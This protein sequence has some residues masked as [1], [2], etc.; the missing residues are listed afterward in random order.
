MSSATRAPIGHGRG[1]AL[2]VCISA[3]SR[4]PKGATVVFISDNTRGG[5]TMETRFAALFVVLFVAHHVGDY[6]VQVDWQAIGK[7]LPTW[8][9][10][11]A[12]AS[13]VATYTGTL[14]LALLGASWRLGMPLGVG[15]TALGLAVSAVT[16]YAADRRV[17]F[18]RLALA[19]GH[20]AGWVDSGGL[21][22]LDQSWHMTWLGVAAIVMT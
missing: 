3:Y 15:Q 5:D 8:R 2:S 12:C 11:L 21:A 6:W 4:T 9:G 7:T 22:F 16:H 20:G 14:L 1:S 19:T 18:R 10:R 13:H 17:L